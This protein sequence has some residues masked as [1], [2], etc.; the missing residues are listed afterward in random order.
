MLDK[1]LPEESKRLAENIAEQFKLERDKE[2]TFLLVGRSGVG[3]SST[4]NSLMGKEIA[5]VGK[6]EPTT[7]TVERYK[8]EIGGVKFTIIDTPGLCDD[9]EEKGNDYEYLDRIRLNTNRIDLMWFVT[10]LGESRVLSDEKRGIKL[11]SEA[12]NPKIWEQAI[13]V[14]TCADKVS[15]EEYPEFLEKRTELIRKEISKYSG[16]AIAN[17]IPSIAVSNI[18]EFTPDGERWIGELYTQVYT[19]MA[20]EGAG[21]FFMSTVERIKPP[22]SEPEIVEKI[23][24]VPS[25]T[26]T[27]PPIY[28]NE[29]QAG[30]VRNRTVD[31]IIQSTEAGAVTGQMI[32]EAI[33][34]IGGPVV[35]EVLGKGG[36]VVG[37][38]VGALVGVW[39]GI[40][41]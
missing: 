20:R 31:I 3:K 2:F 1:N 5:P 29:R 41:G 27:A 26:P 14:F 23:V 21:A 25:P 24:Y 15:P 22:K 17:N 37:G 7:M 8:S 16:I 36:E 4:A 30:I 13:I 39:K 40:F 32:G 33:G 19:R 34:S 10:E 35:S 11:I 18:K 12:F 28:L 6:F 9:L 38:T